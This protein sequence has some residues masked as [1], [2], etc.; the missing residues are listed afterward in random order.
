MPPTHSSFTGLAFQHDTLDCLITDI[1]WLAA[2]RAF[3][4]HA[5]V[6]HTDS[7]GVDFEQARGANSAF[8]LRTLEPVTLR[9]F[10]VFPANDT[11]RLVGTLNR[12][13]HDSMI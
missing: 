10:N 11:F 1:A 2:Y 6:F 3:D 12:R 8:A 13:L 9:H 4:V 7:V 5:H